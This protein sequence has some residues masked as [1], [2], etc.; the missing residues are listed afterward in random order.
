MDEASVREE[1]AAKRINPLAVLRDNDPIDPRLIRAIKRESRRIDREEWGIGSQMEREMIEQ[2]RA[3]RPKMTARLE[4]AG[5]LKEFA[6]LIETRRFEAQK[7]YE[8]AGMPYPDSRE[9]AE[10]EWLI[11]DPE[12]D[13]FAEDEEEE[14][15][16]WMI[17]PSHPSQTTEQIMAG[18]REIEAA[19]KKVGEAYQKLGLP[20]PYS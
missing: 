12:E 9:Q 15:P 8:R 20:N 18:A 2:W 7:M 19:W 17:L 3:I 4:Q 16:S 11:C 13:P 6:H 5:I 10:Q 14:I 1:L